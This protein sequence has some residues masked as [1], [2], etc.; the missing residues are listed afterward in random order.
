[1]RDR[2]RAILAG[3]VA[4]VIAAPLGYAIASE[5]ASQVPES[6][7]DV[8]AEDCSAEIREIY[9][10]K[11]LAP[12]TFSYCPSREQA[13][14]IATDHN[15]VLR[16]GLTRLADAMRGSPQHREELAQIEQR[17]DAL[18]GEYIHPRNRVDPDSD[19]RTTVDNPEQA[20][21]AAGG[22]Y[23]IPE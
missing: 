11:G 23:E 1:M 19:P 20:L 17:L 5:S 9:A 3:F 4:F 22:G 6:L 12:D 21:E 2:G 7:G 16:N 10:E 15:L 8:A 13:E 14:E 18:G